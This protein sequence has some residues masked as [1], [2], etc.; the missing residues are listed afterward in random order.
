MKRDLNTASKISFVAGG[1]LLVGAAGARADELAD[2]RASQ[3]A[4]IAQQTALDKEQELLKARIDQLAQGP[5]PG[6]N[7]GATGTAAPMAPAWCIGTT[8]FRTNTGSS[9]HSVRRTTAPTRTASMP[10][11]PTRESD[12]L[13][14]QEIR[15]ME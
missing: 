14:V 7:P 13:A 5:N 2:L 1:V 10:T 3:A 9:T 11:A 12:S 15:S 8:L 4:L 6:S